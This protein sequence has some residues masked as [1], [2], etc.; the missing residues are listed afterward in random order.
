MQGGASPHAIPEAPAQANAHAPGYSG[1]TL[2]HA[3]GKPSKH[4]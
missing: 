4:Y 1:A 3:K 2:P